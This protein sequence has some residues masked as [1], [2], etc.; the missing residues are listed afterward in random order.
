M[1]KYIATLNSENIV[2]GIQQALADFVL[3]DKQLILEHLDYELLGKLYEGG[4]FKTV[5]AVTPEV[6]TLIAL[7]FFMLRL[8]QKERISI[9]KLAKKETENGEIALD[10]MKLLESQTVINVQQEQVRDG[11]NFLELIGELEEG[12]AL[13]ILDASIID[14]ERP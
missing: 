13:E 8:T 4:E 11:L 10:F 12:R 1:Y 5:A 2:T 14:E 7:G 6:P 3:S 9:R